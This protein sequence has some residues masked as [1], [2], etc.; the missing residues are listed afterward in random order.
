MN[1][2]AY[3]YKLKANWCTRDWVGGSSYGGY[4]LRTMLRTVWKTRKANKFDRQAP[5][6]VMSLSMPGDH[7]MQEA[8]YLVVDFKMFDV[9]LQN[10]AGW[11][12][13]KTPRPPI[14]YLYLNPKD[15]KRSNWFKKTEEPS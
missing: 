9:I 5:Q 10:W 7:P 14:R 11:N 1:K 15:W 12:E 3:G 8:Y 2:K 4:S 6:W 13:G